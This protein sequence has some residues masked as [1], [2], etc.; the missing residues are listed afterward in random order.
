MQKSELTMNT[1]GAGHTARYL[2][3]THASKKT[4]I[5]QSGNLKEQWELEFFFTCGPWGHK[6]RLTD[7]HEVTRF[8]EVK[9]NIS[10]VLEDMSN[11]HAHRFHTPFTHATNKK[12]LILMCFQNSS[13]AQ[14]KNSR[15]WE[16][17]KLQQKGRD[18]VC[19]TL[20]IEWVNYWQLRLVSGKTVF[21]SLF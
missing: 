2:S 11:Y 7:V 17:K 19:W 12:R 9:V 14:M 16:K 6:K 18:M 21:R 20:S 1:S 13:D 15:A 8:Q 10:W 5:N 4:E 3:V